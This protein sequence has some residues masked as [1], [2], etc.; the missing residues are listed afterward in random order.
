MYYGNIHLK[1]YNFTN[2]CHPITSNK[3]LKKK[4]R[5]NPNENDV[6]KI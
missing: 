3:N 1:P 6:I 2:Q 5:I 4:K